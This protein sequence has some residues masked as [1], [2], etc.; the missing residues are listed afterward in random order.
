MLIPIAVPPVTKSNLM[1]GNPVAPEYQHTCSPNS[2]SYISNGASWKNLLLL[3][4]M[5][6]TFILRTYMFEHVVIL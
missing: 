2:S 4:L 1:N 3:S 5:I 6:I